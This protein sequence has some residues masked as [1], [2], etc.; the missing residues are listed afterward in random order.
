MPIVPLAIHSYGDF[1]N[2]YLSFR[3]G[4]DDWTL[5][6]TLFDAGPVGSA[7]CSSGAITPALVDK[8][9]I[10]RVSSTDGSIAFIGP[11]LPTLPQEIA[12]A[13]TD[14][15]PPDFWDIT[16]GAW[17]YNNAWWALFLDGSTPRLSLTVLK[18]TDPG[19][20]TGTWNR[21]D[22][23]DQPVPTTS[24]GVYAFRFYPETG[25]IHV[26]GISGNR[27]EYSFWDFDMNTELWSA[28]FGFIDF[29]RI[30]KLGCGSTTARDCTNGII[31]FA[32]GDTGVFY[33]DD[34]FGNV[35]YR[36]FDGAS[37]GSEFIIAS[38]S[39]AGSA[40]FANVIVDPSG[41]LMHVCYYS[42]FNTGTGGRNSAVYETVAHDGTLNANLFVFPDADGSSGV[43]YG[44]IVG[45]N[46][47]IPYDDRINPS[48][49]VFEGNRVWVAPL[50]YSTLTPFV[51]EFLPIPP[52]EEGNPPTCA[53]LIFG[54]T[55]SPPTQTL[56]LNKV[57]QGGPASPSD[58]TL[59]ATGGS[60]EIEISG[61]GPQVGPDD[62]NPGVFELSEIAPGGATWNSETGTWDDN[63]NTWDGGDY[64]PVWNCGGATMPTPTSVIVGSGGGSPVVAPTQVPTDPTFRSLLSGGRFE[65]ASNGNVYQL[66]YTSNN[67]LGMY[68]RD[69]AMAGA[70]WTEMDAFGSP[71]QGDQSGYGKATQTGAII[72][73]CYLR[74]GRTEAVICTFDTS[75]DTWGTP[76]SALVVESALTTFGFVQQLGGTYVLVGGGIN[77]FYVATNTGGVWAPILNL[78]L[79]PTKVLD[80]CVDSADAIHVLL[81]SI[82]PGTEYRRLDP[83][84]YTPSSPTGILNSTS[85]TLGGY[86]TISIWNGTNVAI[87]GIDQGGAP[88]FK[89]Q[90]FIGTPLAA[91]AF[92]TYVI[93]TPSGETFSFPKLAEANDTTLHSFY[94]DDA[95][96]GNITI[97]QSDFNG[98][99]WSAPVTF[100]DAVAQPPN[101]GVPAI[102]QFFTALDPVQLAP[103]SPIVPHWAIGAAME[104]LQPT[105]VSTAEVI[106]SSSASSAVVCT[107]TNIFNGPPPGPPGPGQ[108]N[109]VG[110]FELIR[111]DAT[112]VPARHLPTRGSTR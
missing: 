61:P 11:G 103:G 85:L 26:F 74:I 79:N 21:I 23:A 32:N 36:V 44:M 82:T 78:I 35:Y 66:G 47:F 29:G 43:G 64:T 73:V 46:I 89:V 19:G 13:G 94:V 28:P 50:P 87:T 49:S 20:A 5:E 54:E 10:I 1:E 110:C 42:H 59:I 100:Y 48:P 15:Q 57:V 75:T 63:T 17:W 16:H 60:P 112:L 31:R 97:K 102:D 108:M 93:A 69:E 8:R 98:S 62:V 45:G 14:L 2:Y 52:A 70:S 111:V 76:T 27:E 30:V 65:F 104:T 101:S 55:A 72:S 51:A 53:F 33:A 71:E 88:A 106:E 105:E 91:P 40:V 80:A 25:I 39:G 68:K 22:F 83:T 67:K 12:P 58:F 7:T 84:T 86:P 38:S 109:P 3:V 18:S 34:S 77:H 81:I 96:G 9:G 95:S 92:T 4:T 107:V 56:Q 99:T 41:E 24:N 37:W 90:A 6:A